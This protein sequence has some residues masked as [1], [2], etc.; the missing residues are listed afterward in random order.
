VID[1][2]GFFAC[3]VLSGGGAVPSGLVLSAVPT[4]DLR[5][6]LMNAVAS[7]LIIPRVATFGGGH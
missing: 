7:R 5:S 1:V 6:G 3:H 4:P 2:A